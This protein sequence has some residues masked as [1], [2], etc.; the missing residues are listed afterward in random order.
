MPGKKSD[1]AC[2]SKDRQ[3]SDRCRRSKMIRLPRREQRRT[4]EKEIRKY[5]A[6]SAIRH[7][8]SPRNCNPETHSDL[9]KRNF[10]CLVDRQRLTRKPI[11]VRQRIQHVIPSLQDFVTPPSLIPPKSPSA[12]EADFPP[13][14]KWF[15]RSLPGFFHQFPGP[16]EL[17]NNASPARPVSPASPAT[18]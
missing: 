15:A 10:Y 3:A 1:A 17:A 12:R 18:H 2:L 16:G 5:G 8:R 9:A 14:R 13:G 4:D 6:P 11:E 7:Y